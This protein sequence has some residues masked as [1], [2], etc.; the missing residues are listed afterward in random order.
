MNAE[1]KSC[2]HQNLKDIATIVRSLDIK[3]LNVNPRPHGHQTSQ[4]REEAMKIPIIVI[5]IQDIVFII[6]NLR[7]T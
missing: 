7:V 4:Q 6:I 1:P 5:I 2:M 3:P